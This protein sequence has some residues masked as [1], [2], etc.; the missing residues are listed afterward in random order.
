[1]PEEGGGRRSA[2]AFAFGL[3]FGLLVGIYAVTYLATNW[4]VVVTGCVTN[5]IALL[6]GKICGGGNLDLSGVAAIMFV[7]FLG[8]LMVY[9]GAGFAIFLVVP[10]LRANLGTFLLFAIPFVVLFIVTWFLGVRLVGV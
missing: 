8:S 3:V 6:G 2:L 1:M 7:A 9:L 10:R 5:P 4:N